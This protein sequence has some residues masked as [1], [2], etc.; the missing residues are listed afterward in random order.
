MSSCSPQEEL[1]G[2]LQPPKSVGV[3]GSSS[4]DILEKET[5]M[6]K[7]TS[8]RKRPSNKK[9][10]SIRKLLSFEKNP[11][12]VASLGMEVEPPCYI[13]SSSDS[14]DRLRNLEAVLRQRVSRKLSLL[15]P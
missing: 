1:C 14:L 5:L 9:R 13:H 8:P 11:L 10:L 12:L 2:Y 4:G 15:E 6:E 3:P 7:R